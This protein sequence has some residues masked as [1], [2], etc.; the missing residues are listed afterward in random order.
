MIGKTI[1]TQVLVEFDISPADFFGPGRCEAL[2][3]AR[4][5]VCVR[6]KAAGKR[7]CD[8]ARIVQLDHSA[9]SYWLLPDLRERRR[10]YY[11]DYNAQRRWT[12]GRDPRPQLVTKLTELQRQILLVTFASGDTASVGQL[13]I[14]FGVS[15]GY[16]RKLAFTRS[17]APKPGNYSAAHLGAR[18]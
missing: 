11:A 8:I 7:T 14:L 9:V 13:E 16:T 3:R 4:R 17:V 6:L 5:E 1:L 15:S 12:R 2:S 18:A 10:A